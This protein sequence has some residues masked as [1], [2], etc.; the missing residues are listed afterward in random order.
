[1]P[2]VQPSRSDVHVDRPLT[3]ISLAFMQAS[4]NFVAD[5]VFPVV[6]SSKQSD[7]FF[8]YDRGEFNRDEMEERAPATESAGGTYTIGQDSYFARVRAFHRDIPDQVRANADDPINLEAEAARYVTLKGMIKREVTWTTSYFT[9]TGTPGTTW[10]FEVD[11]DATATAVASF[12]PTSAT[13]NHKLF[14]SDA[15]ST[16][17]EDVRQGKRFVL[18]STGFAPNKITLGR[19]VFDA[20]LD[21]P[22]IVGRLDRGQTPTGPAIAAR[23]SI[24]ALFELDEVLVMDA[25]QNT[26]DK[27]QANASSFIGTNN[28]LLSYSPASPGIMTPSAGY[29][30]SWT[31]YTGATGNGTRV[32]RFRMDHIEADRVEIDMAYDQKLVSADLGY[33][34]GGITLP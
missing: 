31:G 14:W 17:I 33:I 8:T 27:G 7:L 28:A 4:T 23:E 11:G 6:S 30:F 24:A 22:D 18:E 34:F 29:T 9:A 15:A 26:A 19:D 12:D 21:H 5:R 1:M 2:A 16:P 3:Q 10:T 25:I 20:L 32:K 13:D